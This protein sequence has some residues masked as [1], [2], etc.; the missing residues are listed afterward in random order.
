[1]PDKHISL[2]VETMDGEETTVRVNVENP[3]EKIMRTAAQQLEIDA[4]IRLYDLTLNGRRLDPEQKI[5]AAGIA[6]GSRLRLERRPR[7]G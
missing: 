7:V 2:V 4:D 1:M 6:D 5:S 3:V